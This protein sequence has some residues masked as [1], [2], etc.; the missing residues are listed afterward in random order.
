MYSYVTFANC[1]ALIPHLVCQKDLL[2]LCA[3]VS[4]CVRGLCIRKVPQTTE[5]KPSAQRNEPYKLLTHKIPW[6]SHFGGFLAT[7]RTVLGSLFRVALKITFESHEIWRAL[8]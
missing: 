4:L 3:R 7:I 2:C 8:L 5:F 6:H 1:E